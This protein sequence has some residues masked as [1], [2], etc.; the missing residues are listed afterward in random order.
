MQVCEGFHRV[1]FDGKYMDQEKYDKD[2]V[3][4]INTSITKTK[5]G[6]IQPPPTDAHISSLKSRIRFG[7]EK[8]LRNRMRELAQSIDIDLMKIIIGGDGGI[9]ESWLITRNYYTH[10]DENNKSGVLDGFEMYFANSRLRLF[11]RVLYLLHFGIS[12][13]LLKKTLPSSSF[14][15]CR[16]VMFNNLGRS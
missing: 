11:T 8:S 16:E 6:T 7:N 14:T 12:V 3:P 9:P 5:S 15:D 1:K 10:W 13:D 4:I 2:I